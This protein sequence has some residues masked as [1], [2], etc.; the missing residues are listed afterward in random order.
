MGKYLNIYCKFGNRRL[1][2]VRTTVSQ[3]YYQLVAMKNFI[4]LFALL[5]FFNSCSQERNEEIDSQH[6]YEA[7][8]DNMV[9]EYDISLDSARFS[10][11][12]DVSETERLRN[13]IYLLSGVA[14]LP[15]VEFDDNAHIL[16]IDRE[17]A[18]T[19]LGVP[20]WAYDY[21]SE[22]FENNNRLLREAKENG[23]TIDMKPVI[24]W[25]RKLRSK[26]K[27]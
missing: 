25:L 1:L 12:M 22:C 8:I 16:T 6:D 26:T 15:Y 11:P 19:E 4:V 2:F 23:D 27:E 14:L 3:P 24:E 13:R 10:D 21:H 17:K 18:W 5:L 7:I 20:N 9:I